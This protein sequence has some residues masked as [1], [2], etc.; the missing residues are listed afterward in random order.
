MDRSIEQIESIRT[1]EDQVF[2]CRNFTKNIATTRNHGKTTHSVAFW[3]HW[4]AG[5]KTWTDFI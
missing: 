3:E 5:P 4:L 1:R 2:F